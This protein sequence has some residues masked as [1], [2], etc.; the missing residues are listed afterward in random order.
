MTTL[1][2]SMRYAGVPAFLALSASILAPV[3]VQAQALPICVGSSGVPPGGAPPLGITQLVP[4]QIGDKIYSNFVV[5]EGNFNN[6]LFSFSESGNDHTLNVTT[7]GTPFGM[8]TYSFSY[9]VS[10]AAPST[11]FIES[12]RTSASASTVGGAVFNKS[13]T[14]AQTASPQ[15]VSYTNTTTGPASPLAD[16]SP[17]VSSAVFTSTLVVTSGTVNQFTDSLV[18]TTDV[19][20][21]LPILGAGVAFG[22]SRNL[23]RRIAATS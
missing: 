20:G 2:R 22:F 1:H 6:G 15:T 12:F 18:Q 4:C 5:N 23:R 14:T 7:V 16:L 17:A 9:T 21:P 11:K 13:L 8:G 19:P 10:V 3:P